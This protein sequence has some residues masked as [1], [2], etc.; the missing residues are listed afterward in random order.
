MW[1]GPG[2]RGGVGSGELVSDEVADGNRGAVSGARC[3]DGGGDGTVAASYGNG[4]ASRM[5]DAGRCG[6]DDGVE[7]VYGLAPRGP[8]EPDDVP[9]GVARARPGC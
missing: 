7:N 9:A 5:A 3:G 4:A 6:C 1:P 8:G 2:G